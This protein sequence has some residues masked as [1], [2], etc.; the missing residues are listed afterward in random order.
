MAVNLTNDNILDTVGALECPFTDVIPDHA[1]VLRD[2]NR[3]VGHGVPDNNGVEQVAA[4]AVLRTRI[5][6]RDQAGALRMENWFLAADQVG[7]GGLNGMGRQFYP[8]HNADP[9]PAQEQAIVDATRMLNA[10]VVLLYSAIQE[11]CRRAEADAQIAT[12]NLGDKQAALIAKLQQMR[13]AG[14][15]NQA[16][17]DARAILQLPVPATRGLG[18]PLGG[19]AAFVFKKGVDGAILRHQVALAG[20]DDRIFLDV[21]GNAVTAANLRLHANGQFLDANGQ[22]TANAAQAMPGAPDDQGNADGRQRVHTIATHEF[23]GRM[24]ILGG[25]SPATAAEFAVPNNFPNFQAAMPADNVMQQMRDMANTVAPI[26]GAIRMNKNLAIRAAY[27]AKV[28]AERNAG[29]PG[30]QQAAVDALA[31][32]NDAENA[33]AAAQGFEQTAVNEARIAVIWG[34]GL[35]SARV[36]PRTNAARA[37]LLQLRGQ[38]QAALN[39]R[40]AAEALVDDN[41]ADAIQALLNNP[42]ADYAAL[43]A[44]QTRVLALEHD[45]KAIVE[46]DAFSSAYKKGSI[47]ENNGTIIGDHKSARSCLTQVTTLRRQVEALVTAS[48]AQKQIVD[49]APQQHQAVEAQLQGAVINQVLQDFQAGNFNLATQAAQGLNALQAARLT[50]LQNVQTATARGNDAYALKLAV[51]KC[52]DSA[53]KTWNELEKEAKKRAEGAKSAAPAAV[54]VVHAN[55]VTTTPQQQLAM[56]KAAS[57][58]PNAT[59]QAFVMNT[60]GHRSK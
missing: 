27:E 31:R 25:V 26:M 36:I 41:Q 18:Q 39:A 53:K 60:R 8:G 23:V 29:D 7:V 10:M 42:G 12:F 45:T 37:A 59:L 51:V 58:N 9:V 46:S 40:N 30:L 54:A 24:Q 28:I 2:V 1:V 52:Q 13:Q 50:L 55:G 43:I 16:R 44:Q 6:N 34:N 17:D 38:Q 56:Q 22:P 21:E 35:N 19:D 5:F 47:A 49:Q 3:G 15:L 48:A 20:A 33:Y 14:V 11:R 57:A 4:G 32:A